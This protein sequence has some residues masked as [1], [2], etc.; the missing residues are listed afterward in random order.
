MKLRPT[1]SLQTTVALFPEEDSPHI[2]SLVTLETVMFVSRVWSP[3]KNT[4][5]V[6]EV[7]YNSH[8][9]RLSEYVQEA[10]L[11]FTS[12]ITMVFLPG[13]HTLDT[14]NCCSVA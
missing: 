3:G 1:D 12:N 2:V 10:E 9:A 6:L 4:I 8:C 11:Y 5:V 13:D 14:N 7:K